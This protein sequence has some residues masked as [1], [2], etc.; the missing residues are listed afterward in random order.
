MTFNAISP[1]T[2]MLYFRQ[3]ISEEVL[4]EVQ[5][6]YLRLKEIQGIID[7]TASYCSILV[8]FDIF[9]H[10][11]ETIKVSI[12]K[13]LRHTKAFQKKV[14]NKLI[15]IPT[16]YA[17]NLDLERVAHH[18][19]LSIE[20]VINYH[21][22]KTYRVYAIGFMIGFAYLATVNKKIMTPRLSS[23]RKKVPQ[24]A[25]ALADSQTAIYPQNSAGGW[26]IIGQTDFN[27]FHSFEI[28][29]RVRFER[30]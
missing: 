5:G 25:V 6:L 3:E 22:Q 20:E 9:I 16:N 27:A 10:D 12:Q 2:L 4:D 7:L 21:S 17:K 15:T 28:G 11:H 19:N 26:N 23:P 18:N 14:K 1:D 29:D 24:G 13:Q 30:I 8:Q